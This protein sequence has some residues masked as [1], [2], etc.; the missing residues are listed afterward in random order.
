MDICVYEHLVK[1]HTLIQE[2]NI[3]LQEMFCDLESEAAL[4]FVQMIYP[5]KFCE[6]PPITK[7]KRHA[8]YKKGLCRLRSEQKT[9]D[10]GSAFWKMSD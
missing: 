3:I 9:S 6:T 7:F 2:L 4:W 8:A 1:I 5:C 10:G